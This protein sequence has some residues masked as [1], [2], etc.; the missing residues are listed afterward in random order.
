MG[1]SI[2]N[3]SYESDRLSLYFM[4]TVIGRTADNVF[5]RCKKKER[6]KYNKDFYLLFFEFKIK[7]KGRNVI[8]SP[9][10]RLLG[11]TLKKVQ[12]TKA[13]HSIQKGF[14]STA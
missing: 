7:M 5:F 6:R 4:K 1:F 11:L 9:V 10:V 8:I 13:L 12:L 14:T 2:Q 3:W